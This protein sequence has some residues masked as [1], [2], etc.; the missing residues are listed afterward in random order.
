MLVFMGDFGVWTQ[1]WSKGSCVGKAGSRVRFPSVA[2]MLKTFIYKVFIK[3]L[4]AKLL[5]I[6]HFE[7][8]LFLFE[9][10]SAV[11]LF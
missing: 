1:V 4:R 2:P 8:I 11:S 9:S 7:I 5:P 10:Y 3:K 6:V